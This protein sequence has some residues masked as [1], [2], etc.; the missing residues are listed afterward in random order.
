[1]DAVAYEIRVNETCW[2]E[3]D[4]EDVLTTWAFFPELSFRA[5]YKGVDVTGEVLATM[6]TKYIYG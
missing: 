4:Y 1:M 3:A 5:T 6:R 2:V